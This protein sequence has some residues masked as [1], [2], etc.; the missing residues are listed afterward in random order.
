[1]SLTMRHMPWNEFDKLVLLTDE[2]SNTDVVEIL[3]RWS[4]NSNLR[5]I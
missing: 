5:G 1:M 3:K 2:L 4:I